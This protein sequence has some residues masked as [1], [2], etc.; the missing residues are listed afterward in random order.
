MLG[1]LRQRDMRPI[2]LPQVQRG[3]ELHQPLV[4]GARLRQQHDGRGASSGFTESGGFQSEVYLASD[5]RLHASLQRSDGK[6]KRGEHVV[7][8]RDRDSRHARFFAKPRQGLEANGPFKQGVFG[9]QAEVDEARFG[10][11]PTI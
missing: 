7:G 8:V 10:H 9:M 1:Q 2:R 4:P 11:G 3:I 5:N 6:L